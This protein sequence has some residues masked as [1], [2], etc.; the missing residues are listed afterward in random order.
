MTIGLLTS[1]A[2]PQLAAHVGVGIGLPIVVL[3]LALVVVAL[4]GLPA[5]NLEAVEPVAGVARVG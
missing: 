5:L 1:L 2:I 3:V 4:R